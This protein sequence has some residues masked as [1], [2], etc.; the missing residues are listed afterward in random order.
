MVKA[1]ANRYSGTAPRAKTPESKGYLAKDYWTGAPTKHRLRVH[2]VWIPKYRKRVLEG[3]VAA[4]LEVLL[5]EAAEVNRWRI[6]ELAIQPDHVHLLLQIQPTSS[7]ASVVKSLK[8]GTSRVRRDEFP[9]LKE[10]L[11]G[12]SF[13]AQGYFAESVGQVEESVVSAYIRHQIAS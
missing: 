3:A 2:L 11:W 13:W 7:I 8:G 5:H 1:N 4:R 9:E 10:F 6:Q 12:K